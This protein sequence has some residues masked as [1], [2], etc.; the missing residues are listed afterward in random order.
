MFQ[1]EDVDICNEIATQ[2]VG[3]ADGHRAQREALSAILNNGPFRPGQL[4]SLMEE[5]HIELILSR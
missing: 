3:R 1:I 2:A 4:F 5:Q